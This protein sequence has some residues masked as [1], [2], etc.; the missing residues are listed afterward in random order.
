MRPPVVR[1]AVLVASAALVTARAAAGADAAAPP[2]GGE[3]SIAVTGLIIDLEKMVEAQAALGWTI[4]RYEYEEMMSPAL[5]SVCSATEA[6]RAA[7]LAALERQEA[8]LGGPAEAAFR[9]NG[10]DLRELGE[11]L[12]ITRVRTLL[13]AAMRRAPF[14]CPF[15]LR[16][17]PSF[18]GRE[19][20]AY[21]TTLNMEGG[22]LGVLQGDGQNALVG[23]GGSARLLLGR[24]L[25]ERWTFLAGGEFGGTALFNQD[26]TETRFPIGFVVA[27]PIV[28]R[29]N[30]RTWHYEGEVA[31]LAYFTHDDMRPSPGLRAGALVGVSTLRVRNIMPWVGVGA[32]FEYVFDTAVRPAQWALKAGGRIGF[33][34]DF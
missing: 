17:S 16:P 19:I 26:G 10:G 27:L 6:A 5:M 34:W 21:R 7:A 24:G 30:D 15:W 1:L 23:A 3:Q 29:R 28:L 31:S 25:D 13:A 12:L 4:D 2:A 9:K 14:E 20:D 33:D 11:L 8:A 22:G 18:R 32:A